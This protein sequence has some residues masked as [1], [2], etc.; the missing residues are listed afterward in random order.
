LKPNEEAR[1]RARRE[2]AETRVKVAV[3][4]LE[5]AQLY[6]SRAYEALRGLRVLLREWRRVAALE[7]RLRVL[8]ARVA[9][10]AEWLRR[11]GRLLLD[12]EG[13]GRR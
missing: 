8:R 11:K 3:A 4:A 13:E 12:A 1:L 6:V 2:Q 5:E 7:E 10:R 9:A